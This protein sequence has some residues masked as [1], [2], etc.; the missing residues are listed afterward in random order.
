M[1][2]GANIGAM[3]RKVLVEQYSVTHTNAS[4]QKI[5]GW[6]T[7]AAWWCSLRQDSSG[8]GVANNQMVMS[9]QY[10]LRGRYLQG[11]L[12]GMRINDGGIIYNISG[13][14]TEGRNEMTI[15]SAV[16]KDSDQSNM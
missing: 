14:R 2:R 15:I 9:T 11:V 7:Y 3:D 6:S 8:E 13:V 1:S 4:G 10:T 16:W 5:K 12:P